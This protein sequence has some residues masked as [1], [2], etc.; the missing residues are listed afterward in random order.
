MITLPIYI[1]Q[2][3]SRPAKRDYY[4]D[5]PRNVRRNGG[6]GLNNPSPWLNPPLI[7][8]LEIALFQLI[9]LLPHRLGA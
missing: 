9:L 8:G 3:P 7:Q 2:R 1:Y 6:T 4:L 5:T